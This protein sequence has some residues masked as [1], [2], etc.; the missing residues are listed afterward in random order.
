MIER[1]AGIGQW[2][3]P[4]RVLEGQDSV[5]KGLWRGI[6]GHRRAWQR[7]K[8]RG[9]HRSLGREFAQPT[10]MAV[11]TNRPATTTIATTPNAMT[12]AKIGTLAT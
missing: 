8:Q 3:K 11:P 6:V 2:L 4:M 7:P 1:P 12:E 5:K 10:R 9:E